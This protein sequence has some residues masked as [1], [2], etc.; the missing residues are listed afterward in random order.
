MASLI[1]GATVDIETVTKDRYGRTVGIVSDSETN[2]NQEMVRAGF[3]WVYQRYCDK[4]FCD[5]WL[6][7]ENEAKTGKLGLWQEPDP[8]PPWEW[9]RRK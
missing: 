4:P 8:V 5:Y 1:A 6:A 9:R 2:I 7:L 3:A